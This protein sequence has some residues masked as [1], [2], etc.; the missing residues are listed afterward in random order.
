MK[1]SDAHNVCPACGEPVKENW[2]FCPACETSL[3][4]LTCP[5]CNLPVKENWQRCPECG[6]RL[7]CKSCGQRI[8]AGRPGCPVCEKTTPFAGEGAPCITEPVTGMAFV[9]V[10]S[11]TFMMGDIFDEGLENEKPVHPVS[12]DA[13]CIGRHP[14]TQAQ[15]TRVMTQNPSHF[16]GDSLP[17]EQVAWGDV[18][19]FIEKLSQAGSDA[20]AF[21]L[22]T[23]AEWE[24]AARSAG[25]DQRYSGGDDAHAVA[26]FADNSDGKTHPAGTKAANGLSLHDM[27]G[28]VWEW[29]LD[30]F[31]EKAYQSHTKQNPVCTESG[32]DRVIRG[33]SWNIDQWSVRCSRRFGF[34]E[35]FSGSGLGFRLVMLP[36]VK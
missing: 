27:S 22:P 18:L 9:Q 36:R 12:L 6:A 7:V 2:T 10:P 29:C 25:K 8:P 17:V 35:D 1:N 28:N 26:W 19:S 3:G 16:P 14:V 32:P 4:A 31:A 20:C 30:I 23:E 21:R 34:P 33:G 15:W 11:G 5:L 13:F 24:Y